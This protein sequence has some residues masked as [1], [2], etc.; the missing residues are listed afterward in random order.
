MIPS[1]GR[2]LC[3]CLALLSLNSCTFLRD[4]PVCEHFEGVTDAV[5]D[6]AVVSV[7]I[8]HGINGF[9]EGDPA[10]LIEGMADRLGLYCCSEECVRVITGD[11][12]DQHYGCLRR[13]DYRSA[14]DDTL[15]RFY[16]LDWREATWMAKAPIRWMDETCSLRKK[17]VALTR[18][19]KENVVNSGI[20]DAALYLGGFGAQMRFPFAQSLNWIHEDNAGVEDHSLVA[21]CFSLGGLIFVDTIDPNSEFAREG[22]LDQAGRERTLRELSSLFLLGNPHPIFE[23]ARLGDRKQHQH[24]F[25]SSPTCSDHECCDPHA[26]LYEPMTPICWDWDNTAVARVVRHKRQTLPC[27][28]VVAITDPN[29]VFSYN[30]SCFNKLGD[31]ELPV[32]AN[33]EVRNVKTAFFGLINPATAHTLYGQNCKVIDLITHGHHICGYGE[34]WCQEQTECCNA[35]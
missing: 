1:V 3:C 19:I 15:V 9:S 22:G 27:W 8:T 17:R 29:D 31:G 24:Q 14:C 32:F 21:V 13:T 18:R 12:G 2:L 10:T 33:A 11:D 23:L 4:I 35:E 28:Q 34:H 26:P 30:T 5:E 6:N 16:A 20:S 25:N 7:F